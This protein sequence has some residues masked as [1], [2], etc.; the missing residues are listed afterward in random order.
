MSGDGSAYA[1][2]MSDVLTGKGP[3][4][5]RVYWVRRGLVILVVV[6]VIGLLVWAFTPRGGPSAATPEP[7]ATPS[8]TEP[9]SPTPTS[10]A[11]SGDPSATTSPSPSSTAPTAC[12]PIGVQ[13]S[14]DGFKSVKNDAKQTFAVTVENNTAMPCVMAITKDSFALRVTS[15]SDAIWSTAHCED[16]LPTVKKR[17]LKAG[18]TVEFK[19]EWGLY[20]SNEG[21]KKVK[22]TLGSGTYVA[23]ATY[24]V[25]SSTRMAFVITG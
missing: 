18:A 20:R 15:G 21:C 10:P 22:G 16:W 5:P 25:D 17:T 12:E 3:Q 13:M 7:A 23:T 4:P 8:A 2:A 19:V 11:P 24:A 9:A 1:E 6:V 14:M